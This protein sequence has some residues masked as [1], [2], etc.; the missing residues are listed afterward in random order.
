[1]ELRK[2]PDVLQINSVAFLPDHCF[3]PF[4]GFYSA[5]SA[6]ASSCSIVLK[7]NY[8]ISANSSFAV[9]GGCE[10]VGGF[11]VNAL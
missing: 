11:G 9:V 1:M 8:F 6:D 2:E 3:Q 7:A 5:D 10:S 4:Q